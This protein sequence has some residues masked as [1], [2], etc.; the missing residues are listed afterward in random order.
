MEK[1]YKTYKELDGGSIERWAEELDQRQ[2][3][4]MTHEEMELFVFAKTKEKEIEKD[5]NHTFSDLVNTWSGT[6]IIN[7]RLQRHTFTMSK[8]VMLFCGDMVTSPGEAVMMLNYI[9]YR[10]HRHNIKHVNMEA[11]SR[12]IMPMGWFDKETLQEFWEKQKY[13]TESEHLANML[14]NYEFGLTIRNLQK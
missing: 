2:K 11:L 7:K 9:Q 1:K 4:E 14:D 8:A 6:A 3:R 13:V 5:K 12:Y 10:C